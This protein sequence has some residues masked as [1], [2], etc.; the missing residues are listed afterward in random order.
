MRL[1]AVAIISMLVWACG[2]GGGG[3]NDTPDED[4]KQK[5][6]TGTPG[7]DTRKP[8]DNGTVD[9]PELDL[10]AEDTLDVWWAD[11]DL[12]FPPDVVDVTSDGGGDDAKLPDG[13][14]DQEEQG[15]KVKDIQQLEESLNCQ[16]LF[17]SMLVGIDIPLSGVVV[18]ASTYNYQVVGGKLDGFYVADKEGG[19]FSGIHVTFPSD[20]VPELKPGMVL[21]LIGNHKEAFCMTIFDAASLVVI[22]DNGDEPEPALSTPGEIAANP[23]PYEGMLVKIQNVTVTSANP[24]AA[25]GLDNREFEVDGVLRVGNDYELKYMNPGTDGRTEGDEFVHIIGVVKFADE[26]F[27]LMPR[28][29]KDMWL[30]GEA[31]P[32]DDQPEQ[33]VEV[34]EIMP[35]V[36]EQGDIVEQPEVV[37]EVVEDV[38]DITAP[39]VPIEDTAE[40]DVPEEEDIQLDIPQEPSSPIVITEIMYDPADIADA[41]GEW[42][43]IYNAA[44]DAID[45][46]G[47]RI[48]SEDGAFHFIQYGGQFI[49][50]P[51]QFLVFGNNDDEATNGEVEVDYQYPGVDYALDNG[52]DSIILKNL[53]GDVV[54]SVHYDEDGG[55]PKAKGKSIEL[56]HPNLDND[57]GSFWKLATAPYGDGTNLG[58]PGEAGW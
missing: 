17:G 46:N 24:D 39:D 45:L 1:G 47:W 34:V 21:D 14:A 40:P 5:V 35:E 42:F 7:F 28:S 20:Q 36:V 30:V 13:L 3:N 37:E 50:E 29:E 38:T 31:Q 2:G 16:V 52:S 25:D 18:T 57:N 26:N 51:G 33:T 44:D 22:D 8:N 10:K 9:I 48:D 43:E 23:E 54:D 32:E 53:Y 6:D 19:T 56:A 12:Y 4:T 55:F 27:H 11:L 41:S 58:T 15:I 49:I